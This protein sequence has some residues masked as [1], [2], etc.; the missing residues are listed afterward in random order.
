MLSYYLARF[1]TE[2]PQYT[3]CD[4][5]VAVTKLKEIYNIEV[6]VKEVSKMYVEYSVENNYTLIKD[7][8]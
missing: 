8:V 6:T 7:Y 5:E 3:C 4:Y 1:F 2:Y